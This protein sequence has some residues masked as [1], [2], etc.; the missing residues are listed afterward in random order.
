MKIS[1]PFQQFLD[2][3]FDYWSIDTA[4]I[5]MSDLLLYAD[6]DKIWKKNSPANLIGYTERFPD[7]IE[8]VFKAKETDDIY[9]ADME[10]GDESLWM[11][12]RYDAYC[13]WGVNNDPWKFFP[14][15]LS[16]KD[17]IK[18]SRAL[19]R[20]CS[21][22]SLKKWNHLV[23]QL[24]LHA[25]SKDCIRD[26]DDESFN[27]L[28][29]SRILLGMMEACHLIELRCSPRRENV[30]KT[31]KA[32][33]DLGIKSQPNENTLK[34]DEPA[35]SRDAGLS[36]GTCDALSNA[37]LTSF[38]DFFGLDGIPEDMWTMLRMALTNP[39]DEYDINTRSNTIF[40]YEQ[41][42]ALMEA[43]YPLY[44]QQKQPAS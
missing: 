37:A 42:L 13:G 8:A 4:R 29:I 24:M 15:N 17:F 40:L 26:N 32:K 23:K 3:F 43:L 21:F 12:N 27:M 14:R 39:S 36:E 35:T 20:F 19:N 18:P 22:Q 38:F 31:W 34:R 11:L 16:K 5:V 25:L 44:K 9:L 10:A 1:N 30:R 41:V 7:L 33:S 28:E 2:A 6:A